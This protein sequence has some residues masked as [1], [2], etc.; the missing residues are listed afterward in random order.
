MQCV[1]N[2]AHMTEIFD[3]AMKEWEEKDTKDRIKQQCRIAK[4]HKYHSANA[5]MEGSATEE[6]AEA[7]DNLAIVTTAEHDTIAD[8]E[9]MQEQLVMQNRELHKMF[10]TCIS[11][12]D[13]LKNINYNMNTGSGGGY[14]DNQGQEG[15]SGG[16][17]Y[18]GGRGYSGGRVYSRGHGGGH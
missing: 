8:L 9:K 3:R 10:Q 12:I 11:K 14:H 2:A 18:G 17:G 7:L 15:Y 6:I 16:Q 13:N 4:Q 5:L 1:E